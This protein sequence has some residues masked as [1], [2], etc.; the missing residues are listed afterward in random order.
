MLSGYQLVVGQKSNAEDKVLNSEEAQFRALAPHDRQRHP[1]PHCQI[2]GSTNR[3]GIAT[4]SLDQRLQRIQRRLGVE[5]ELGNPIATG[6]LD[7][8]EQFVTPARGEDVNPRLRREIEPER[9]DRR[10][11]RKQA[12]RRASKKVSDQTWLEGLT[13]T[14]EIDDDNVARS[15]FV[16][17][18]CSRPMSRMDLGSEGAVQGGACAVAWTEQVHSGEVHSDGVYNLPPGVRWIVTCGAVPLVAC[19]H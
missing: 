14:A 9:V 16:H 13:R 19:D 15:H 2:T 1:C 11:P 12:Q 18:R 6:P 7:Q 17:G 3:P 4:H 10:V 8:A 5:N